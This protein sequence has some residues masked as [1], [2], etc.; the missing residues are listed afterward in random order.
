M[1]PAWHPLASTPLQLAPVHLAGKVHKAEAPYPTGTHAQTCKG[2]CELE[3]GASPFPKVSGSRSKCGRCIS[4][5]AFPAA[6]G[7]SHAS[8]RL[9]WRWQAPKERPHPAL[10]RAPRARDTRGPLSHLSRG[11][12]NA[13]GGH[14]A[15]SSSP[16]RCNSTLQAT[17]TAYNPVSASPSQQTAPGGR[18][19]L[20]ALLPPLHPSLPTPGLSPSWRQTWGTECTV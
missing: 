20:L 19:V 16:T 3:K 4:T 6:L 13:L 10:R 8:P 7:P 14:A 18:G 2:P 15:C 1:L 17:P 9:Q 5:D 12:G 11:P